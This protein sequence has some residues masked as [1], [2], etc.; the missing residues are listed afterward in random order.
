MEN[1]QKNSILEKIPQ[2]ISNLVN[3]F[4]FQN[5]NLDEDYT[6]VGILAANYFVVKITYR[7]TLKNNPVQIMFLRD[8]VLNNPL[9]YY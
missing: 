5:N 2:V 4:N 3:I 6:W 9:I 1:L 7:N 8:M